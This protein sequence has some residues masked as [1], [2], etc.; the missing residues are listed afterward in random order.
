MPT[1]HTD[2]SRGRAGR[3]LLG[4]EALEDRCCPTTLS[5]IG[6]TLLIQGSN[7]NDV[8]TVRDDGIGD[9]TA[10]ITAPGVNKSITA[11]SVQK[12]VIQPGN[13]NDHV[14]YQLTGNLKVASNL[15][16]DL[17]SGDDTVKLDYSKG[18]SA[19]LVG[20]QLNGGKGSDT[21]DAVFGA[22]QGTALSVNAQLGSRNNHFFASLGNV[23]GA[24]RVAL[25]VHGGAG[26]NGILVQEQGAIGALAQV[27]LEADAGGGPDTV[28]VNYQGLLSG[29]LNI[30]V[31][32]GTKFDLLA[33]DVTLS[34]GSKG[35]LKD[36]I[37]G[38][39]GD[40]LLVLRVY[41]QT[42]KLHS[43]LA[44]IDGGLGVNVGF[45][46]PNVK[47]THVM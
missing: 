42:S 13:G 20:V 41:G 6:H 3:A 11:H 26:F 4:V 18:I 8:V 24:A 29:K 47:A 36:M 31:N 1:R 10:N 32:G 9:V 33:S 5:L 12:V 27:N 44:Q 38:G 22:V 16:V 28:H 40:D 37:F 17:G 43:Y 35:N 21:V 45:H 39:P 14:T 15:E 19:P 7:A 34:T 23:A 25:K 46:T 2:H 30:L